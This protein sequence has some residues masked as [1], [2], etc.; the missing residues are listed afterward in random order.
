M[1]FNP[2][3]DRGRSYQVAGDL[4][5]FSMELGGA[6]WVGTDAPGHATELALAAAEAGYAT[7]VALGGDGTVHEVVNGLMQVPAERRP[8]LGVVPIG[9]GNDFVGSL[10]MRKDPFDAIRAV[11]ID[12]R[13]RVIDLGSI[14]DAS[15]R[16]EYWCNV[17]GIG[18]DAAINLQSRTI[19]WIHGF[20]MYLLAALKTIVFS[21]KRP[22]C[23][24]E[25][26]GQ[27]SEGPYL[28]ISVG[29][30]TRAGGGF[31]VT[32]N[33]DPADGWLDYMLVDPMPR[34]RMLR[35]LPEVMKGTHTKFR[36]VHMSRA[37][38]IKVRADQALPIQVD[39][40]MFAR[41]ESDVRDVEILMHPASLRI[42]V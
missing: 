38:S 36:E 1:I 28:M 10:K 18:F 24:L 7:V 6:D 21:F 11:F 12:P 25:I 37:R 27:A 15:G 33:A 42:L 20:P 31:Y 23:S 2:E 35:L 22:N 3:A 30:G 34:L 32:P 4:R 41:Y 17:M 8:R 13:E 40:E 39:G 26:D 5:Q 16:M 29:N 19:P 9:S 14:R